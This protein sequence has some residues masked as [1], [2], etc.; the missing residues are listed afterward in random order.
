[1]QDTV[2]DAV[3]DPHLGRGK[4]VP[5]AAL[6]TS[7][8]PMAPDVLE[9]GPQM[10]GISL[11]RVTMWRL[12]DIVLAASILVLLAPFLILLAFFLFVSDPGPIF[13]AHRRVGYRGRFFHCLKF[14]TMHVDGDAILE[15][16]LA[17]SPAARREWEETQKLRN[18]PRITVVGNLVR[19]FSL[20][21]F[22]QL[23]N[24]LAGDMSIVGPRP[25]VLGEVERYGHLFEYYCRVRPGL[26]GLWQTSGRSDI[27]FASRVQMDLDYVLRKGVFFDLW[28]MMK[29]VPVVAFAKGAY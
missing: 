6:E 19:K 3:P 22:P 27:C 11:S 9:T 2:R 24:V 18:D 8:A 16:H 17:Q 10:P 29:T 25:I 5:S 7:H 4:A 26:T 23:L 21:E 28:L 1:M 13:Y 15:R 20:D 14:R 12:F